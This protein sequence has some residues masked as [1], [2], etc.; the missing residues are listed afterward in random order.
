MGGGKDGDTS[1]GSV[2]PHS[3]RRRWADAGIGGKNGN[4]IAIQ[5]VPGATMLGGG[6]VG[7]SSADG[8]RGGYLTPARER[9]PEQST[10]Q[11]RSPPGGWKPRGTPAATLFVKGLDPRAP[12]GEE[13]LR[14][15][16]AQLFS[17]AGRLVQIRLPSDPDR[18]LKGIAYVV[19]ESPEEKVRG[20]ACKGLRILRYGTRL[21]MPILS[22]ALLYETISYQPRHVFVLEKIIY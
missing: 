20:R 19:F 22:C 15:A 11:Q 21:R 12:G 8:H 4:A 18:G 7:I 10:L 2:Q 6:G 17:Q 13:G 16:L 14:E 3:L 5:A 1:G 9:P